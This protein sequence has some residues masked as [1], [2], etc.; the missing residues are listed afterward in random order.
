MIICAVRGPTPCRASS[1]CAEAAFTSSDWAGMAAKDKLPAT[2]QRPTA[3]VRGPGAGA[4][5]ARP[6]W[7]GPTSGQRGAR[8]MDGRGA[9][10]LGTATG[11]CKKGFMAGLRSRAAGS[12]TRLARHDAMGASSDGAALYRKVHRGTTPRGYA[13]ASGFARAPVAYVFRHARLY[14][15]HRSRE[16]RGPQ[17][18]HVSLRIALVAAFQVVRERDIAQQPLFDQLVQRQG[19]FAALLPQGIDDSGGHIVE[20][21]RTARAAIENTRHLGVVEEMQ[22]DGDHVVDRNEIAALPAVGIAGAAG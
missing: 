20:R 19:R 11:S 18:R 10:G 17:L 5:P 3:R 13:R 9:A 6:G 1:S 14:V 21:L 2:A 4:W 15:S 22:I 7:R 8:R 16:P 12:Q